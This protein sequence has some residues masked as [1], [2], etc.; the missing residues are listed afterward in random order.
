M[1]LIKEIKNNFKLSFQ[2]IENNDFNN[3]FILLEKCYLSCPKI[4]NYIQL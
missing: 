4:L 2:Y 1:S 3:A